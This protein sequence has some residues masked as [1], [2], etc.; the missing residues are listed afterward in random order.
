MPVRSDRRGKP[1]KPLF[2]M[3]CV[4][5]DGRLNLNAHGNLNQLDAMRSASAYGPFALSPG[6]ASQTPVSLWC[7]QGYGPAEISLFNLF[8]E[9]ELQS[10]MAGDSVRGVNGRYGEINRNLGGVLPR[11]GRTGE[12]DLLNRLQ[13]F[14]FPYA[15]AAF[16]TPGDFGTPPDLDDDGQMALD[17][18]GQPYY[19]AYGPTAGWG[20]AGEHVDDPYEMN[21]SRNV[22]GAVMYDGNVCSPIDLQFAPSE[23]AGVLRAGDVDATK[24]SRR[25]LDLAP[26]AF[27]SAANRHRVTTESWDL[28]TP[29][30]LATAPDLLAS[31][32]AQSA[33][34]RI[35]DLSLTNVLRARMG[36]YFSDA[37]ARLLLAPELRAGLRL[38]LNRPLGDGADDNGNFVVD[39]PAEADLEKAWSGVYGG[40][41]AF[42]LNNDG[43]INANDML[44]R[45][46]F[47]RHLY[48]LMMLFKDQAFVIDRDGDPSNNVPETARWLAQWAVNVV[49]FRDR[50]SIMT[51]FAYD[52]N[53]FDGWSP[54]DV[55]WGCERPQL[56]I[57]ETLA[58]HDR[59]TEDLQFPSGLTTDPTNPDPDFDQRWLPQGSLYVEL[60]NP[61]SAADAPPSEFSAP[62]PP[63]TG[64]IDLSRTD[65]MSHRSPVWRLLIVAGKSSPQD[66]RYDPDGWGQQPAGAYVERSIY[67]TDPTGAGLAGDGQ[68][69]YTTDPIAPLPPN[70]YAVLGPDKLTYI[71]RRID[72][73][74][75]NCRRL[76]QAPSA[77]PSTP[78]QVA[79]YDNVV[80]G[81]NS[82]PAPDDV[83]PA[84][85]IVVNKPRRLS[86]SEPVAGYASAQAVYNAGVADFKFNPP[87]D[88]P[89]DESRTYSGNDRH[90]IS[91]TGT[92]APFRMIHL[93]RLANPLIP[94][95]AQTNPY[96]TI[97]SLP[98]DLTSFTGWSQNQNDT[99]YARTN[100]AKAVIAFASRQRG[101]SDA[102]AQTASS[103][104]AGSPPSGGPTAP[105]NQL[106]KQEP[107]AKQ[108][109]PE[110]PWNKTGAYFF[111]YPAAQSLGYLNSSYYANYPIY[112]ADDGSGYSAPS[113]QGQF[114]RSSNPAPTGGVVPAGQYAGDPQTAFPWLTWNNRPFVSGLEILLAPACQSSQLLTQYSLRDVAVNPYG[115]IA[116]QYYDT[117]HQQLSVFDA[118]LSSAPSGGAANLYRCLDFVGVPS[119]FI[120]TD[121]YQNPTFFGGAAA[122]TEGLHPPFSHISTYREPGRINLNTIVE[123]SAWQALLE[124]FPASNYYWQQ[125]VSSRRGYLIPGPNTAATAYAANASFPTL[126]AHP[127]RSAAG[128]TLTPLASMRPPREIDATLLRPGATLNTTDPLFAYTATDAY[129]DTSRNPYFRYQAITKLA[130]LTTTRSN[131]Y[132]VWITMGDF[133]VEAVP[134][135]DAHPDGYALGAE[136]SNAAGEMRRHRAFYLYDRT[137]PVGFQRG[138]DLNAANGLLLEQFIE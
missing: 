131:V 3:L 114:W 31:L 48:V 117:F 121:T 98:V 128:G 54:S 16:T 124:G 122:G 44:A 32:Y 12:E 88:T 23:L 61:W 74:L 126:F 26:N 105:R 19:V 127:F 87:L 118:S 57:T 51:A 72:G 112:Y 94:Y 62:G 93:Q 125:L 101:D 103:G 97:D 67:F 20:E 43:A 68:E 60:F 136:R 52:V 120:A 69:Y 38:D 138:S 2:A 99:P 17:L 37:T 22:M 24:L 110:P 95:N 9:T 27:A 15:Y 6:S 89:L 58:F 115:P 64:D 13:Q 55:V 30:L 33:A 10:L 134:I 83:K 91:V 8:G 41:V 77:D 102:A 137:V 25:I 107:L 80:T 70:Q 90:A 132:A 46:D 47:A 76:A 71:G 129:R 1:Y 75:K 21:L 14:E 100:N 49:D 123:A 35:T 86:V 79:M 45:Q 56:L 73:N 65:A 82:P 5:L 50:D 28:P 116:P 59:A 84:V 106:W 133:E 135:D 53:P 34:P 130:N 40:P 85:A 81:D 111:P 4:D 119:R 113:S 109:T 39:E 18:R 66:L 36:T 7:G 108:L 104:G 63:L 92:T 11:P 78:G 96:R 29:S 42:D